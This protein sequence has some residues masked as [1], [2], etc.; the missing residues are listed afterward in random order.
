MKLTERPGRH[1]C[2]SVEHTVHRRLFLEGSMAAGIASI[3]SYSGLFSVPAL[4]DEAKRS[5][6][7]C[8]LLWLCGAPSQ[9]EMWDPKP[10]TPTGGP[11]SAIDTCLPGIQVSQLM[12][13]CATILDKL[14]VIRSMK[15]EP[16]EHFQGIDALTR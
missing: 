11:F 3:A 4:A 12:P 15:T 14:A 2:G 5:G 9:F 6:K 1:E 7:K 10:G 8:I 13:K 16:S